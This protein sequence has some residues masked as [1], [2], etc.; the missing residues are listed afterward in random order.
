MSHEN[1]WCKKER[2]ATKGCHIGIANHSRKSKVCD[3]E[4][5]FLIACGPKNVFGFDVSVYNFLGMAVVECIS[6][7]FDD[8]YD[9]VFIL[10][11]V[12][13]FGFA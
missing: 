3:F 4:Y 2:G 5:A 11:L 10:A 7:G 8:L 13:I 12:V 6:N 9:L 1:L